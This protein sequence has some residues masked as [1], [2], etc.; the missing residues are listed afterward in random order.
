MLSE[1][2]R[3]DSCPHDFVDPDSD[4]QGVKL[5]KGGDTGLGGF[6]WVCLTST[7]ATNEAPFTFIAVVLRTVPLQPWRCGSQYQQMD[8]GTTR[9]QFCWQIHMC[10]GLNSHYF[11]IIGVGHQPNSRDLY[12]HNYPY[13]PIIRIPIKGGMTIPQKM[14]L[15]MQKMWPFWDGDQWPS[16]RLLLVT[17]NWGHQKVTNWITGALCWLCRQKRD[18]TK[19]IILL[20]M[21]GTPFLTFTKSGFR[22]LG[23]TQLYIYIHTHIF[24][25]NFCAT[26]GQM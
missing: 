7:L 5:S 8:I 21:K 11:H 15:L 16:Q 22:C 19:F 26:G 3:S 12:T 23:K 1:S 6:P 14:R 4:T 17:S 25:G 24:R 10:Q 2:L 18:E 9:S 20:F 13:I